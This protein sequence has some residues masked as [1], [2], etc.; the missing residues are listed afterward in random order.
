[1][2]RFAN[3]TGP[4]RLGMVGGGQGAMIGAVHRIAARLDGTYD[5]VAGALS[6]TPEKAQASGLDLGLA[7]DRI[8]D[9][10]AKMAARE[11][12]LK[13]GIEAV[14][15]VTPNHLHLPAAREFLK[16]GIHVICDKPL[17]GTMADARKLQDAVEK[18]DALF[19]LTHTYAGYPMVREAADRVARGDLGDIRLV[20]IEYAQ[21]W[22][23]QETGPD[24]KQAAWRTDPARSGPGGATG[25]IGTHAWHLAHHISGLHP[26]A[27]AADL[28]SFVPGRQLDD[29]AHVM[30]RYA[31]GARGML[32]CSQVAAGQENNLRIRVFG[33]KAGLDWSQEDP[34][35][36][37]VTPLEGPTSIIT[38]ASAATGVNSQRLTRVPAGH[39]EG[40]FEAFAN[41]YGAAAQAII[42]QRSGAP[43][44]DSA[45]FPGIAD[46][47]SGVRFVQACVDSSNRNSAWVKL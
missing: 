43:A 26:E 22:L 36:L 6:S 3:R 31:G 40:Y 5:L 4:I 41:I 23:S 19:V 2:T 30:L 44:P 9:D 35:R 15:I 46:G 25:D 29:N 33:T 8:Y 18:S 14:A 12:R 37:H 11:A 27:L 39:P 16:R 32:W 1:M 42:A 45:P 17:T 24:N 21:S 13:D 28:H 10:F 38:R 47:M 7:S 34:N 20:Q